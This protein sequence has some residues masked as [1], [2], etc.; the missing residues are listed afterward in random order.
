MVKMIA[1]TFSV[2]ECILAVN[3]TLE[4]AYAGVVVEG[5]VASYKV[6]QGKF[7]F[8]DIKDDSGIL[9]CFSMVWQMRTPLEDGMRVAVRAVPKL[10]QKGRFSLTVQD[11]TPLGEG[12]IARSFELL[13]AKLDKEGLF[14][15]E[16]KRLIPEI[17]KRIAVISSTD[18]AG[19]GD[20]IKILDNRW[21][22]LAVDVAHVQVQ[23]EGAEK[24]IIRA[25]EY[26]NQRE[27]L[28]EVIVIVR[29]GGSAEDL[30]TFNTEPIVRAIAASRA[31]VMTGIGHEQ[32]ITLADLV[33]DARA[34]TPSNAAERLVPDKRDSIEASR[35]V[36][37]QIASRVERY[38]QLE[39]DMLR[40]NLASAL[41]GSL[42]RIDEIEMR[43]EQLHS[44]LVAYNP[45]RVLAR[46]YAIMRGEVQVGAKIEI[47]TKQHNITAEVTDVN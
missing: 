10:T 40:S 30:Q 47:E 21:G 43:H 38:I 24:Q 8:F 16:R 31:P 1:P 42:Q 46:G 3:Q 34:S 20:F 11:V 36:V 22:G 25:L 7:I 39:I 2:S 41:D 18:A 13:K 26:F 15:T 29:G 28:P 17:P 9:Q 6:N 44:L 37:L 5:E 35:A 19:Y 33:A 12:A 23:G 32:D 4:Y 27:L 14:S 45:M